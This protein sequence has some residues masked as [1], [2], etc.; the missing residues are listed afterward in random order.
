MR[1]PSWSACSSRTRAGNASAGDRRV[2]SATEGRRRGYRGPCC[3]TAKSR[4]FATSLDTRTGW[5]HSYAVLRLLLYRDR[6][7]YTENRS[8]RKPGLAQYAHLGNSGML[9]KRAIFIHWHAS[10]ARLCDELLRRVASL[11][12]RPDRVSKWQREARPSLLQAPTDRQA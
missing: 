3:P 12:R 8:R 11:E 5:A 2:R 4:R 6:P 1:R 9:M 10:V 7:V